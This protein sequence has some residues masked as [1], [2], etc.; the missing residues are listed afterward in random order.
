MKT[1]LI[2][3]NFDARISKIEIKPKYTETC[4]VM[5]TKMYDNELEKAIPVKIKYGDVGAFNFQINSFSNCVGAESMGLF[6]IQNK[7]YKINM[8]EDIFLNRRNIFL[9]E[10]WYA[11]NSDDSDDLLNNRYEIIKF[12]K[13]ISKYHLYIQNVDAGVYVILAKNIEI[14]K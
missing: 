2:L 9:S 10:G 7:E 3:N 5:T 13:E 4:I 12:K 1:K 11:Y 14:I 8:I 6:E